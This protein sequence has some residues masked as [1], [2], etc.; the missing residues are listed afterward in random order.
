MG[1]PVWLAKGTD[2]GD[3]PDINPLNLFESL[4]ILT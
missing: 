4:Q 1:Y 3:Q 2:A